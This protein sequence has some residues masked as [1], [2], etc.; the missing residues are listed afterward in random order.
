MQESV[1]NIT[2]EDVAYGFEAAQNELFRAKVTAVLRAMHECQGGCRLDGQ[3]SA[4]IRQRVLP[5]CGIRFLLQSTWREW[6]R[7][8]GHGVHGVR[9]CEIYDCVRVSFFLFCVFLFVFV[10]Q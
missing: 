8:T 6:L 7:R 5:L 4:S 9:I 2:S 1:T 10:F 3:N